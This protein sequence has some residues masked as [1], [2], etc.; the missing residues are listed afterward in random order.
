[1]FLIDNNEGEAGVEL[2]YESIEVSNWY[3]V[4]DNFNF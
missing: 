4:S 2:S 3:A 1:M